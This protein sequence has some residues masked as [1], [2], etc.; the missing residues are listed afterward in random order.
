MPKRRMLLAAAA[1]ALLPM[2]TGAQAQTMSSM[3]KVFLTDGSSFVCTVEQTVTAKGF[4]FEAVQNPP[5]AET[6]RG[7]MQF[8]T[9]IERVVV[10]NP[11]P[12]E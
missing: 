8:W 2:T 9:N 1:L 5:P 12:K 11:H 6:T 10:L 4:C 7:G 3:V